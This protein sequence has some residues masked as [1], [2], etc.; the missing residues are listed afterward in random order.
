[1]TVQIAPSIIA[2][3][4]LAL[5][6]AVAAIERGGADLLHVDIMDGHFVP[7]LTIGPDIVEALHER[8]RLPLDVHLMIEDP[9][10]YLDT[11]ARAG[12]SRLTVHVEAVRHLHRTI[13]AIRA[14]GLHPGVALNP[15]TPVGSLSEIVTDVDVVL[16]MTVNPGFGGQTFIARS[17]SK[18]SEVRA[19]IQ[20][21]GSKARIEVDG[22]VDATNTG[23]LV[24]AGATILVAGTSVF[25]A[26]DPAAAVR[27]LR[28]AAVQPA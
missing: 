17:P 13:G 7:N 23:Q 2:A 9:D 19:L 26:P 12:A 18:V 5:G 22:G 20:R 11:F 15:G 6:E 1:V 4:Y 3:D 25:G 21:A 8:T 10:K 14:L 24:A 28:D 16:V 27:A